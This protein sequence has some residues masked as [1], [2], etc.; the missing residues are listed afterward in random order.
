MSQF[1]R[2]A[3]GVFD[4]GHNRRGNLSRFAFQPGFDQ[5][6][7]TLDVDDGCLMQKRKVA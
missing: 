7:N 4:L 5:R 3:N 2:E 1:E 6:P